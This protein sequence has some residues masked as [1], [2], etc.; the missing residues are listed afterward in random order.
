MKRVISP[1]ANPSH[2][3]Q[4]SAK[5]PSWVGPGSTD[6]AVFHR[7]FSTWPTLTLPL[8]GLTGLKQSSFEDRP[9]V[10]NFN[11]KSEN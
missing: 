7:N 9:G 4:N 6:I 1:Q 5:K 8:S 11:V 2:S 3:S 10:M